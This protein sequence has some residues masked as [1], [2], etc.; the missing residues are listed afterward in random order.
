[1][2]GPLLA[3]MDWETITQTAQPASRL[4]QWPPAGVVASLADTA[5]AG[6][7]VTPRPKILRGRLQYVSCT[8]KNL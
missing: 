2:P 7:E 5:A 1:L 6:A 4:R 3:E 8:S